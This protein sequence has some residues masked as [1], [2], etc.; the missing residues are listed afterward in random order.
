M[1]CMDQC[2]WIRYRNTA[3]T[4][5]KNLWQDR[6][7]WGTE[8]ESFTSSRKNWNCTPASS[9]HILRS[10]KSSKLFNRCLR[11]I[12]EDRAA[13]TQLAQSQPSILCKMFAWICRLSIKARCRETD[14]ELILMVSWETDVIGWCVCSHSKSKKPKNKR[15][16]GVFCSH[17]AV[18]KSSLIFSKGL[19]KDEDVGWVWL[20]WYVYIAFAFVNT[21]FPKW[22]TSGCNKR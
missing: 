9:G 16:K 20:W 8:R 17:S 5:M 7:F 11:L 1:K 21:R 10:W 13:T 6:R 2:T 18:G 15:I 12:L 22:Y 19:K 14:H 4:W 3:N